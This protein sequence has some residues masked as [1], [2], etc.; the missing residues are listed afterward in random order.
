MNWILITGS[1]CPIGRDLRHTLG[2]PG[3]EVNGL[4]LRAAALERGDLRHR[5]RSAAGE[6]AG[7]S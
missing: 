2:A 5:E 4:D 7:A 3:R 1:S 6:H